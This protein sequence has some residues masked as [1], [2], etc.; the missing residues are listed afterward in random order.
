[1]MLIDLLDIRVRDRSTKH[2]SSKWDLY[3]HGGT[4]LVSIG[5]YP[6]RLVQEKLG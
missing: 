2:R 5:R 4:L 1:M 6:M 3:L